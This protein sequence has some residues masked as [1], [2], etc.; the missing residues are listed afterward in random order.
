[1]GLILAQKLRKNDPAR[2]KESYGGSSSGSRILDRTLL[3]DKK[4]LWS[5]MN[6]RKRQL[7]VKG[8]LAQQVVE[9]MGP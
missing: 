7:Y 9:K 4:S 8:I 2:Q 5:E 6:I 3:I 1:V